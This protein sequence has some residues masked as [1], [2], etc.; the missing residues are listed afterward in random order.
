VRLVAAGL[1]IFKTST[2]IAESG[3][4]RAT[5]KPRGGVPQSSID[6]M[7]ETGPTQKYNVKLFPS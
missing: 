4:M 7:M 3:V 1:R 5:Y 2:A 6:R